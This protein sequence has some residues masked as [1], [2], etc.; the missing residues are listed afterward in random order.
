MFNKWRKTYLGERTGKQLFTDLE[1]RIHTYNDL[2]WKMEFTDSVRIVIKIVMS[3]HWYWLYAICTARVHK[4]IQQTKELVFIDSSSFEDFNHPMFFSI[5]ILRSQ[6]STT[7]NSYYIGGENIHKAMNVL[8]I[9]FP[10][11]CIFDFLHSMWRWLVS[12]DN[13]DFWWINK[14]I[15]FKVIHT[16]QK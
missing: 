12:T 15:L 4:H 7:G 1:K 2:H 3:S 16:I 9:L 11:L 13:K 5:H 10:F 14:K 8:S 6:G